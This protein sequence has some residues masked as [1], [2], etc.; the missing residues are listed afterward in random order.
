MSSGCKHSP[1]LRAHRAAAGRESIACIV[2]PLVNTSRSGALKQLEDELRGGRRVLTPPPAS[3]QV[4]K[5]LLTQ[6]NQSSSETIWEEEEEE[7][8]KEEEGEEEEDEDNEQKCF[9]SKFLA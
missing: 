6:K 3:G 8:E 5:L 9:Q 1:E 4:L 7:E 2:F